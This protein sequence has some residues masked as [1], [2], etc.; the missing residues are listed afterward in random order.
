MVT[1][2]WPLPASSNGCVVSA[3]VVLGA[4]VGLRVQLTVS[5][6]R[7]LT[8]ASSRVAYLASPLSVPVDRS[9]TPLFGTPLLIQSF[10]RLVT[11]SVFRPVLL[12]VKLPIEAAAKS[13]P[14]KAP[15]A[16]DVVPSRL[17][18]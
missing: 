11:S 15:P 6:G 18:K 7:W 9:T 2:I 12:G 14:L 8:V 16:Q 17:L 3:V 13:P 5:V 1:V 4:V 10:T